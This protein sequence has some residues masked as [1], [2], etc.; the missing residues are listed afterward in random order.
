[1]RIAKEAGAD[2]YA[3]EIMKEAMQDLQNATAID[4]N[5]KG[6]RKMEIT[7]ARQAVQ[8]AED[9]RLVTLRKQAAERQLNAETPKRDAQAQ[10]QQSQ[11]EAQQAALAAERARAAQAA[12]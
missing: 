3:P 9:A 12:G 5:K 7:F 2:K 1:M 6:D 4:Q 10:A 8:R 11:L